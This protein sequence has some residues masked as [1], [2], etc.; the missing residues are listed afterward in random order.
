MFFAVFELE[1]RGNHLVCAQEAMAPMF[2]V[3]GI[4]IVVGGVAGRRIVRIHKRHVAFAAFDGPLRVAFLVPVAGGPV[5]VLILQLDPADAIDLLIDELLV[6]RR[7]IFGL[8]ERTLGE[9]VVFARI[10]ADEKV[11]RKLAQAFL[12]P[13]PEIF[14][15]LRDGVIGVALD[16]RLA[17]RVAS[18]TRNP[19]LI[20]VQAGQVFDE[21]I[22]RPGEQRNRVVASAAIAGGLGAVLFGHDRLNALKGRVHR[23]VPMRARQPFLNDLFVA[24]G[25]AAGF[26]SRQRPGIERAAGIRPRQARRKG[27]VGA[28]K[29]IVVGGEFVHVP[30]AGICEREGANQEQSGHGGA[31]G[32]RQV[33]ER[34]SR[35]S[36]PP[37]A[38]EREKHVRQYCPNNCER[39]VKV[40]VPPKG[41][42]AGA[43]QRL[44]GEYKPGQGANDQRQQPDVAQQQN[45]RSRV[46][47]VVLPV[48]DAIPRQ[49]K[50]NDDPGHRVD[51]HTPLGAGMKREKRNRQTGE[52]F[53]QQ[54]RHGE[55]SQ[56]R[57]PA[58]LKARTGDA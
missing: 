55:S 43:Q 28:V 20:P 26:R 17:H 51:E 15:G 39:G 7:A 44:P 50:Q 53:E 49:R 52:S 27:T 25:R 48:T 34:L 46:T 14:Q 2:A 4:A 16:V 18:Q 33:T 21:K 54:A 3:A 5:V 31:E 13:L 29:V 8:L 45:V 38:Q 30:R 12:L 47:A 35:S 24:T 42:S 22:F 9:F 57:S 19:F 32:S 11:A 40:D 23:R 10:G 41:R 36:F 6:A 58:G 1:H 56:K 37:A